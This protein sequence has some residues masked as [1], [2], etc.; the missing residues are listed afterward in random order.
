MFEKMMQVGWGDTDHNA[1][2]GNTAYLNKS[3]DVRMMY[4]Q[5][6][7]LPMSEFLKLKIGP[8]VFRDEVDYFKEFHLLDDVKINLEIAGLSEDGSRFKVRN[9]FFKNDQ[10]AARV[11][12]SLGWLDLNLRKLVCPPEK[13]FLVL[14]EISKSEDFVVLPNGKSNK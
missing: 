12:S 1:H 8:V 14:N 11:T 10:L 7:G 5:E 6:H 13:I 9:S 4:F 2:M 3:V